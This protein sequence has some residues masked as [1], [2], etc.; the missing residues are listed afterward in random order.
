M[1]AKRQTM[2]SA[3]STALSSMWA[4]ACTSAALPSSVRIERCFSCVCGT[5]SGLGGRPGIPAGS[6]KSCW[7][8]SRSPSPVVQVYGA[9]TYGAKGL[10]GVHT[11]VAVK[12]AE[13]TEWTVYEV[14]GWRLG[15]SDS[16][17][18]VHSRA[19]DAR[20]YGAAPELYA[21]KRG[22]GVDALI[23]RI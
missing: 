10:F 22:P 17:M 16:A 5:R 12:P 19:P 9:R 7:A 21:D 13:A 20:W 1:P 6:T 11:W 2:S 18:V 23:E 4:S 14:V 15:W 3:R 8:A